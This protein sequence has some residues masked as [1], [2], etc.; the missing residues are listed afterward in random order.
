M[1]IENCCETGSIVYI[2]QHT[3]FLTV[4][5]RDDHGGMSET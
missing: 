2:I 3:C 1:A 5:H 4:T